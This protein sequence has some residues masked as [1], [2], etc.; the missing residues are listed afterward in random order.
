MKARSRNA[1]NAAWNDAYTP[2]GDFSPDRFRNSVQTIYLRNACNQIT[3]SL[4]AAENYCTN[5]ATTN[6]TLTRAAARQQWPLSCKKRI[7]PGLTRLQHLMAA[8]RTSISVISAYRAARDISSPLCVRTFSAFRPAAYR[9][10]QYRYSFI[11]NAQHFKRLCYATLM[12]VRSRSSV[13]ICNNSQR[14]TWTRRRCVEQA[15]FFNMGRNSSPATPLS[16]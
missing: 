8:A 9:Y 6:I 1:P 11:L 16:C 5:A 15:D 13:I 10:F 4:I 3:I 14:W 7:S 12:T 2:A